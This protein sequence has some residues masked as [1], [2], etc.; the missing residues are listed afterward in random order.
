[1]KIDPAESTTIPNGPVLTA[2]DITVTFGN[3]T[4]IENISLEI[5]AGTTTALAGPNGSGKS[6]FLAVLTGTLQPTRGTVT[7]P[8]NTRIGIIPQR[9]TAP[10]NLPL[11]VYDTVAMGRWGIRGTWRPLRHIDR[12]AIIQSIKTMHLTHLT[13]RSL[14]TLSGGERQRTLIAQCLASEADILLIDEPATALDENSQQLI[15][16]A[17]NSE[18]QRGVAIIHATHDPSVIAEADYLLRLAP[19]TTDAP[20]SAKTTQ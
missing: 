12:S 14:R 15:R 4:V 3:T 6:T 16:Q 10:D 9:S 5:R 17:I 8:T 20:D 11:N 18:R 2:T 7:R 1:M 19:P 13:K